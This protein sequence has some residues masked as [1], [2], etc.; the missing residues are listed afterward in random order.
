MGE[1]SQEHQHKQEHQLQDG[2]HQR[3]Q[4]SPQSIYLFSSTHWDREWYQTFQGFRARLVKMM[5]ELIE[6]LENQPDFEVFHLDGQTIV[7]E[8][9]IQ[10]RPEMRGRLQQL[11]STRRILIGPWYCMPDELLLSGESLIQNLAV[12][13]RISKE[14]GA[15]SWKYGY[16][17]DI[18]GHIAQMPQIFKGFDIGYA[19][20]GRGTNEHTT[21][22]HFRWR[23]PDGTECLTFKLPDNYGYGAFYTDVL[24][25]A[26]EQQLNSE[27]RMERIRSHVQ[28]EL[29]RSKTPIVVLMDGLDHEPVHQETVEVLKEIRELYPAASVKHADLTEMGLELE[30]FRAHMPVKEGELYEPAKAKAPYLHVI[31]HTLSSRYPLKQ[32]NDRCQALLEKWAQPL[33]AIAELEGY[34]VPRTYI[35]LSYNY[36]LQNHPHDSICGCSID[37]VHQDMM[38]RFDQSRE[39]SQIVIDDVMR[40]RVAS[41]VQSAEHEHTL[42]LTNP[43]PFRRREVVTVDIDFELDYPEV[44]QEPFGYEM[45]NSFKVYDSSGKEIPYGLADIQRNH[46]VRVYNQH[47]VIVNRHKISLEVDVPAMGSASYRVVPFQEASRYL[48]VMSRHENIAENEFVKLTINGDGT[49]TMLDK[50]SGAIYDKLMSYV[51][52]GEIGDGWYHANPAAD[53]VITSHGSECV[54]ER[55]ETGPSRTVF[56]VTQLMKVPQ[57]MEYDQA[58]I[59][60]S[61]D[62]T[63][64]EITS[65]IGLSMGARHI[66]VETKIVNTAK[67]H[68]LRLN[69]PT[70]VNSDSYFVKQ[71]FAFI[72]RDCGVKEETQHWRE[73]DVPEKQMGGIVGKRREED[74]TGI[75]LV[76]PFGLHE[77]AAADDEAGTIQVTMF[78]SFRK[79]VMTN[80]EEGGQLLQPLTFRYALTML[81]PDTVFADLARLQDSMQAGIHSMDVRCAAEAL[82]SG[83]SFFSLQSRHICMSVMKRSEEKDGAVVVRLYNASNQLDTAELV[84]CRAIEEAEEVNMLEQTIGRIAPSGE[85]RTLSLSIEP[86]GI[87]TYRFTL[88]D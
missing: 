8:D 51:D 38:Y 49:L 44:Y 78:R 85:G 26:R 29:G 50:T 17:C 61:R 48:H 52:D 45:K 41:I 56:Q 43:L 63:T 79:T 23:A 4:A 13:H 87:R 71:P 74:G 72:T 47:V 5:D 2:P 33:A 73:C 77:C 69:L 6:T 66:D 3:E 18:F 35:D 75:A 68:R 54:I 59:R 21:D 81:Q 14:W 84:P 15:E 88:R 34:A 76:A 32:E 28:T 10:I 53:R 40:N 16:I 22:S 80:G 12:G 70:G 31:T 39:L 58:G 42:L 25:P 83:H 19:M 20:L 65:L 24:L 30:S 7:L 60:R 46:K 82:P 67:D 11:I 9:Y 64:L 37:Q 55:I 62:Y 1:Q 86:W 27:G 36:L 57:E